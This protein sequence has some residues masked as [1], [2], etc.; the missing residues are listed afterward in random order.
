MEQVNFL[1]L[2][3]TIDILSMPF[4]NQQFSKSLYN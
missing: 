4:A 2:L 1:F 3:I